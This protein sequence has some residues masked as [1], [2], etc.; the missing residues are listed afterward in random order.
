MSG[1]QQVIAELLGSAQART[2]TVEGFTQ[3]G[4]TLEGLLF[5]GR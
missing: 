2:G 1:L 3:D 4:R 5:W